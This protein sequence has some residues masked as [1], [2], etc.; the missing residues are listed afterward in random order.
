MRAHNRVVKGTGGRERDKRSGPTRQNRR[1]IPTGSA[2]ATASHREP[3]RQAKTREAKRGPTTAVATVAGRNAKMKQ[4]KN[5]TNRLRGGSRHQ[6]W[7]VNDLPKQPTLRFELR[8]SILLGWRSNQLSYTGG[9]VLVEGQQYSIHVAELPRAVPRELGRTNDIS[10]WAGAPTPPHTERRRSCRF[11]GAHARP[12][13]TVSE[14]RS[15]HGP[16][17]RASRQ[18]YRR[19]GRVAPP[20]TAGLGQHMR[21]SC[22]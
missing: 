13:A 14:L 4:K 6:V 16:P 12:S 7:T 21:N 17:P 3:P 22:R 2:R 8:T 5:S 1:H 10:Q 15:A 18:A 20:W 9:Q 19:A 11:H